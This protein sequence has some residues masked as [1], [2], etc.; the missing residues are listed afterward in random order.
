MFKYRL[1][2]IRVLKGLVTLLLLKSK[3]IETHQKSGQA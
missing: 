1:D 3:D 2:E